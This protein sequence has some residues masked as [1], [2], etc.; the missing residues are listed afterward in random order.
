MQFNIYLIHKT[1]QAFLNHRISSPND[2]DY[3]VE[4]EYNIKQSHIYHFRGGANTSRI[5]LPAQKET[6][7][8]AF[9]GIIHFFGVD[10]H[11][12]PNTG[13]GADGSGHDS[14]RHK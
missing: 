4:S 12:F 2:P 14:F 6:L 10:A 11:R 9:A 1:Q 8:L 13:V 7:Y 5:H 3:V